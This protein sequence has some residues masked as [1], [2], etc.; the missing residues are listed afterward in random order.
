[1]GLA[2]RDDFGRLSRDLSAAEDSIEVLEPRVV[3]LTQEVE[4]RAAVAFKSDTVLVTVTQ[5]GTMQADS[6]RFRYDAYADSLAA[7]LDSAQS[8]LLANVEAN[9]A[10]EVAAIW[11]I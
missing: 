6:A 4:L 10:A 8:V 7:T 9:H 11:R 3:A 2:R 5:E 1:M